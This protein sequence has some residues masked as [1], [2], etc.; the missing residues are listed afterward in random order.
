MLGPRERSKRCKYGY[1]H[2]LGEIDLV[3]IRAKNCDVS[4]LRHPRGFECSRIIS[5]QNNGA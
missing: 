4:A 5:T 1:L 3:A 2:A